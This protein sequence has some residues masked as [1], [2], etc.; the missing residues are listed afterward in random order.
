M[1]YINRLEAINSVIGMAV[2]MII[3]SAEFSMTNRTDVFA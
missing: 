1:F 2:Q 3:E